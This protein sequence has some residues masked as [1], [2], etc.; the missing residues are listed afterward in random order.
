MAKKV[1]APPEKVALYR[2]L[3]ETVE[4]VDAKSNFGSDYT[5][6][7]GNMLDLHS[8][9]KRGYIVNSSYRCQL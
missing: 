7:S 4:G 9:R 2:R 5:A 8:T 1:N 3:I 6:I